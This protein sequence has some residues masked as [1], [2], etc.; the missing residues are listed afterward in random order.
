MDNLTNETN[1]SDRYAAVVW[2]MSAKRKA[3]KPMAKSPLSNFCP[4]IF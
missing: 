1:A 4:S 2:A 3:E